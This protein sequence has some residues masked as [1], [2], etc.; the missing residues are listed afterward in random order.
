MLVLGDTSET[1]ADPWLRCA[2]RLAAGRLGRTHPNPSVG[3]VLVREDRP[4]GEGAHIRAG[5]PHAEAVALAEAGAEAAG[6]TAYVTLEPCAHEGRTPPCADALARAGVSRVFVGVADPNPHVSG[7]GAERLMKAGVEVVFAEDPAPFRSLIEAWE[8]RVATGAPWIQAKVALSLDAAPSLEPSA[9]ACISGAS[10]RALTMRLRS[11][12]DVVLVGASTVQADDPSLLVRDADGDPTAEQPKR[13]VLCRSTLP[14]AD[15]QVLHD[16]AGPVMLLVPESLGA[17]AR[18]MSVEHV[19]I[20]EYDPSGGLPAAMRALADEGLS[21]VLV[22]PGPRLFGSLWAASALDE[23]VLYHAGGLG[24]ADAPRL[25]A[26]PEF[27]G[28]ALERRVR[29]VEAG[30]VG[31]DAVTVWRPL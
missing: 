19:S 24:G 4:V 12:A 1:I 16:G 15:A 23:L 14:P 9:Q 10:A 31:V 7:G 17:D 5:S 3:C 27:G 21:R 30:L 28:E 25:T 18:Q 11:R 13:V 8:K 22:E 2:W 26:G 20:V 29:P 6:A